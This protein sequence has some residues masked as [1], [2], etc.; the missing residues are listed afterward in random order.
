MAN[1]GEIDFKEFGFDGKKYIELQK[2]QILDR[3]VNTNWRLYLEIGWKFLKDSHAQRTLPG[4]P[5]D[6][7][8]TIFADLKDKSDILFCV[9]ADDIIADTKMT[10]ENIPFADFVEHRLLV[11][12]RSVWIK[13]VIVITNIDVTNMFDLVLTF[14]RRFQK[15]Q[16]RV[17]EKYKISGYPYNLRSMLSEDGFGWDDHIPLTKNLILVTGVT[18][19]CGKFATCLG[20]IYL[21]NELGIRAW[22]AKFQTFPVWNLDINHPVNLT[23]QAANLD[24]E[25]ENIIDENHEKAYWQKA[26]AI[27]K[28][29]ESFDILQNFAKAT[30]NHKN[31]MIKYSSSID[32]SINCTWMCITDDA[33][34]CKACVDEIQ[35][36]KENY[37]SEWKNDLAEKCQKL[38]DLA[39]ERKK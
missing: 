8:K 26:V 35:R 37:Q 28:D 9:N 22:Y 20:Q 12:E 24:T 16:Y 7:M 25:Y 5:V 21:D 2:S 4:Y 10:I 39:L 38:Y 31:Y 30:V 23:Y 15:K 11:I 6:A 14:E 18:K 1:T 3:M 17:F 32:V 19:N 29:I 36:R 34:I 13:P 33:I 27:N